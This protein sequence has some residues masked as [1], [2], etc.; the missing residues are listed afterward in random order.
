MKLKINPTGNEPIVLEQAKDF[1]QV[2]GNHDDALINRLIRAARQAVETICGVS[3]IEKEIEV[4]SQN[5]EAPWLLPYG[6]VKEITSAD[7]DGNEPEIE[8]DY[9]MTQGRKLE[10]SYIAGFDELPEGLEQ[11]IYELLKLYYDSRGSQMQIPDT[12]YGALQKYSRNL[13]I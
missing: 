4:A 9:V 12:L 3:I 6:P 2:D 5:F 8:G 11:A 13:A 10:V 1:L 7:V